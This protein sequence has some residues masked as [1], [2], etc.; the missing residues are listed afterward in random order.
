MQSDK[1]QKME[2]GGIKQAKKVKRG[3]VSKGISMSQAQEAE[4]K[5]GGGVCWKV[6]GAT[7]RGQP[8]GVGALPGC[9]VQ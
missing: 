6:M 5:A 9:K 7:R 3:P 4:E 2:G 8:E 1:C